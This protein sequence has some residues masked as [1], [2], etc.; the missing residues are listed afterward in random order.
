MVPDPSEVHS[1]VTLS[2]VS[3][4]GGRVSFAFKGEKQPTVIRV[5]PGT[6][7][8]V[9]YGSEMVA[10]RRAHPSCVGQ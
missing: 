6:S 4:G 5:S 8:R 3:D 9:H 1:P 2:A 10:R 7:L